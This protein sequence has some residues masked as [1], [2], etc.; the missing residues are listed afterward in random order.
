M[1]TFESVPEF[2]RALAWIKRVRKSDQEIRIFDEGWGSFKGED[3]HKKRFNQQGKSVFK[4][5]IS[6]SYD[7]LCMSDLLVE[8]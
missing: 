2:L 4:S 1:K 6:K 3:S 7:S 8:G 5:A